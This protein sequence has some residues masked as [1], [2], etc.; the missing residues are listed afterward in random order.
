MLSN[1]RSL[2]QVDTQLVD[3]NDVFKHGD[4]QIRYSNIRI[5]LMQQVGDIEKSLPLIQQQINALRQGE[6]LTKDPQEAT[7]IHQVAE[8]LQLAYN[9]QMQLAS[10]L[11]GVVHA[12][13]DYEPRG[14]ADSYQNE[15]QD[16]Q[17]PQ[18]MRDIKSYLRFDGQRDVI[19]QSE[20][21]AADAAITLVQA[22]CTVNK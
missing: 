1:D 14:D 8:N 15:M 21:A 4:Y 3:F 16:A 9:K 18:Q 7:A 20:N 22:H 2:D 10:D 11:T 13:M 17:M 5:K 19:D 6:T 12:M